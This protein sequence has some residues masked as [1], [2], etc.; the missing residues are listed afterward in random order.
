MIQLGSDQEMTV[1]RLSSVVFEFTLLTAHFCSMRLI[2]TYY[3]MYVFVDIQPA[4]S[5]YITQ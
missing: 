2:G 4:K 3:Q 5:K 1:K